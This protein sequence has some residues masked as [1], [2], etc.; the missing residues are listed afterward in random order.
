MLAVVSAAWGCGPG[1]GATPATA[2]LL[3]A[4][5]GQGSSAA[6]RLGGCV[7][8][9]CLP[10]PPAVWCGLLLRLAAAVKRVGW[11][12]CCTANCTH[13]SGGGAWLRCGGAVQTPAFW[14]PF[15]K[16][17]GQAQGGSACS[18]RHAA[19]SSP[20]AHAAFACC[21]AGALGV[22]PLAGGHSRELLLVVLTRPLALGL[23]FRV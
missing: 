14:A 16:R 23:G 10:L 6:A 2:R 3:L 18:W 4:V 20:A 15:W 11:V 12:G 1:S 17:R 5:G 21:A 22:E 19:S 8:P 13:R 7:L 9:A